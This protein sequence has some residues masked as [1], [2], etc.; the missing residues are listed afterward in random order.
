MRDIQKAKTL[1]QQLH[2]GHICPDDLSFEDMMIHYIHG[3]VYQHGSLDLGL[4]E[5]I[6][7]GCNEINIKNAVKTKRAMKSVNDLHCPFWYN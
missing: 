5:L 3:D 6:L 4:R 1:Y 2:D 7:R